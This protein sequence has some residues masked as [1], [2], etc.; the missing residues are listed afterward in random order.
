MDKKLKDILGSQN[1]ENFKFAEQN[2]HLAKFRINTSPGQVGKTSLGSKI[3]NGSLD[4]PGFGELRKNWENLV[5]QV[6][7]GKRSKTILDQ[8]SMITGVFGHAA[9]ELGLESRRFSDLDFEIECILGNKRSFADFRLAVIAAKEVVSQLAEKQSLQIEPLFATT[10]TYLDPTATTP[11]A[12]GEEREQTQ[13]PVSRI[14]LS[15][16]GKDLHNFREVVAKAIDGMDDCKCIRMENLGSRAHQP[17][18]FC[19]KTVRECQCLVGLIG[20]CYGDSPNDDPRSYTEIEYDTACENHIPCLMFLADEK[21]PFP[22][23]KREPDRLAEKQRQF[24][25]RIKHDFIRGTFT[26]SEPELLAKDVGNAI[27]NW[28]LECSIAKPGP[29]QN[30]LRVKPQK[31][32]A[33]IPA[34]KE[35]PDPNPIPPHMPRLIFHIPYEL[36]DIETQFQSRPL[37]LNLHAVWDETICDLIRRAENADPN[38]V[39]RSREL[40]PGDH[41]NRLVYCFQTWLDH[42][43]LD[44]AGAPK[45]FLH[46]LTAFRGMEEG[47][48]VPSL[49][50]LKTLAQD[51]RDVVSRAVDYQYKRIT[52]NET[53]AAPNGK[54]AGSI[55]DVSEPALDYDKIISIIS[56]AGQAME[57]SAKTYAGNDEDKLRNQLMVAL[58][59]ALGGQ[60]TAETYNFQGKTDILI[61]VKGE[62]KLIAECKIWR[63]ESEFREA[64]DQLFRYTQWRDTKTA[65]II[66]NRNNDLSNVLSK[67]QSA[68][69]THHN[70]KEFD[71][72]STSETQFRYI[73]HHNQDKARDLTL[74]VLVFHL[75]GEG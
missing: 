29:V 1:W 46:G 30:P 72:S 12:S 69:K 25:T 60:A 64:I 67:I 58:N 36:A 21:F 9:A 18:D 37:L 61:R 32:G 22:A 73:F 40:Y 17:K 15:S 55:Q 50:E 34:K 51:A 52:Q 7:S 48:K 49:E 38:P 3:T 6:L 35:S 41:F 5:D 65:L 23:D 10:P 66:F 74:T 26:S 31:R 59:G 16:T 2:I 47:S 45:R 44:G 56:N 70:F 63:G 33:E 62:N 19:I 43:R 28:K 13:R 4:W 54:G 75:P 11:D 14:F 42:L 53:Q 39:V 57:R 71:E 24:Q 27:H 20:H 8:L 68:A